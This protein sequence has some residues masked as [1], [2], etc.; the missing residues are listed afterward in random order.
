[1]QKTYVTAPYPSSRA[2]S[3]AVVTSGAQRV[4]WLAGHTGHVTDDGHPLGDDFDAQARQVFRNMEKTLV[5]AGAT[6]RDIVTMTVCITDRRYTP[7]VAEIRKE[8]YTGDYPASA[9]LTIS[10]LPDPAMLIEIQAIAVLP[11]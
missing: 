2:Y 4:V 11:G 6:L 5:Q 9:T 1:M 3:P 8:F 10:G 7:R